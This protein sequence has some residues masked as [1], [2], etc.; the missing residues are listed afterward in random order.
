MLIHQEAVKSYPTFY[1]QPLQRY[2]DQLSDGH[3][4]GPEGSQV[5][6]A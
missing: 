3:R 1:Q 5:R 4:P 6:D 2:F